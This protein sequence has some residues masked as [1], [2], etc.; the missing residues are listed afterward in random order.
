MG[1]KSK[2]LGWR[3]L[4]RSVLHECSMSVGNRHSSMGGGCLPIVSCVQCGAE[5]GGGGVNIRTERS[6]PPMERLLPL[7]RTIGGAIRVGAKSVRARLGMVCWAG[8]PGRRARWAAR[9]RGGG[10]QGRGGPAGP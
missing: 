8:Q 7:R 4:K 10:V 6:Y 1:A 3:A 9:G 5:R 2:S